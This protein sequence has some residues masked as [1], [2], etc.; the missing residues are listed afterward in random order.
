MRGAGAA[1]TIAIT[2][3]GCASGSPSAPVTKSCEQVVWYRA[4]DPSAT[5]S[6]TTSWDGW[7]SPGTPMSRATDD[8]LF[9]ARITPPPGPGSY[10]IVENGALTNDAF[11]PTTSWHDGAEVTWIDFADCH[12]P[13]LRL[14]G[15]DVDAR[16]SLTIRATF[17]AS[18]DVATAGDASLFAMDDADVVTTEPSGATTTL[19]VQSSDAI[20]GATLLTGSLPPGKHTLSIVAHDRRGIPASESIAVAWSEPTRAA[21]FEWTDAV[22]YQV[23]VDR[24]RK[25]AAP[26]PTPSDPAA[27]AGGTVAGLTQ[28]LVSGAIT[29]LGVNTLWVSPL[30][31]NPDD[32]YPS[33]ATHTAFGYHGYWPVAAR[34]I[35]PRFGSAE[36]V[37]ALLSAAHARGVRVLFD[38]VPNHVH[39]KHDYWTQ[40]ASDGWFHSLARPSGDCVCGTN[41]CPWSTDI[42]DCWFASYLPDL[43]W[44]NDDAATSV[45]SDVRWWLDRFDGDGVRI[46]AVPM[47]QRS[48]AR[49]ITEAFRARYDGGA[50]KTLVLG[51]NYVDE[52]GYPLL[53]Y[54][55]GPGGLDS[56]FDFPLLWAL[57][58]V[59][60]LGTSDMTE[61]ANILQ[62]GEDTWSG[63]GGWPSR[64]IGNHDV[65][66]FSTLAAG[67]GG[68]DAWTPAS[69]V[70]DADVFDR[71]WLALATVLTTP[72]IPTI[73]YGDEI[74]LEGHVDPDSRK[75]MP[76][77]A[78]WSANQ[79]SLRAKVAA[80]GTLRA[81]SWALRRGTLRLVSADAEHLA[82]IRAA[83]DAPTPS[84]ALALVVLSRAGW[85]WSTAV[86]E[87][88]G[89]P[90][91]L[92]DALGGGDVTLGGALVSFASGPRSV[93]IYLPDGASCLHR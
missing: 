54:E 58:K 80:L 22:I 66:R 61:V 55:L 67:D 31:R 89:N 73:Y 50:H 25:D 63:S 14:D 18:A 47:M 33:D 56:E 60:A 37:D 93:Q 29:D 78:T 24:Y 30:Y 38:V 85:S 20:S 8:G 41:A 68:G 17:F 59:V 7:A 70:T 88:P 32:A 90:T 4:I 69:P 21:K 39:E 12:A 9:A 52:D 10:A 46:D 65:V 28:S 13:S 1:L 49:R 48:A 74:A 34:E 71:Q 42:L 91:H 87:L 36:D 35:D 51:E 43:D 92:V 19:H 23:V 64:T 11:V 83:A 5:L 44:T 81:C 6:V 84:D 40:H 77:A 53:R 76:D 57:R 82:F 72:G 62:Q 15:I 86:P 26:P 2:S 75:V 16:G 45:T 27:F 3:L 79:Q